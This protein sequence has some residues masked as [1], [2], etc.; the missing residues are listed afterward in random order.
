MLLKKIVF[1]AALIGCLGLSAC[2]TRQEQEPVPTPTPMAAVVEPVVVATEVA[3]LPTP[4]PTPVRKSYV[5][6]KGDS[7]WE[8][9]GD[10]AILGDN[11]SWPLL[12]KSNRDQIIDP[13]LIE[14]A[15]DLTWKE[16]YTKDEVGDAVNKAKETPP[17]VPHNK[18]RKQLPLKY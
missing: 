1:G 12:F 9:S 15:Q 6:R 18:P 3:V 8:I 17:F 4:V 14:P 10:P 5:V 2:A 13:D 11:F 16:G 7:L